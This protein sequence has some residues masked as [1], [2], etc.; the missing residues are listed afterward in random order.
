MNQHTWTGGKLPFRSLALI[1]QSWIILKWYPFCLKKYCVF[2]SVMRFMTN[3]IIT[4]WWSPCIPFPFSW[5]TFEKQLAFLSFQIYMVRSVIFLSF[6]NVSY[7]S[8]VCVT[9]NMTPQWNFLLQ[10]QHMQKVFLIISVII[11]SQFDQCV[12]G[13]S[14]MKP[15]DCPIRNIRKLGS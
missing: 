4:P 11:H 9:C 5:M 14:L 6:P 15:L 2:F 1:Y 8:Y 12:N 13:S 10:W 7:L 3:L